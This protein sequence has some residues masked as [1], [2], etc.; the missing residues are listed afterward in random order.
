[1]RLTRQHIRFK[2]NFKKI[3]AQLNFPGAIETYQV[4][5]S[6]FEDYD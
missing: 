1:M 5:N 2:A 6:K 4:H 3:A